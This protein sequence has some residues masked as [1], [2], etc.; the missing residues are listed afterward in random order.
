VVALES[1]AVPMSNTMTVWLEPKGWANPDK[2]PVVAEWM[3]VC[4]VCHDDPCIGPDDQC[5]D[6]RCH[7]AV[8]EER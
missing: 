5:P 6:G 1:G 2:V 3:C 4:E 7:W 8:F